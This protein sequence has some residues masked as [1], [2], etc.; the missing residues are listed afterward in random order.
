MF[1]LPSFFVP[2]LSSHFSSF[3]L[4]LLSSASSTQRIINATYYV[5]MNVKPPTVIVIVCQFQSRE[6]Y[7]RLVRLRD[8]GEC[9]LEKVMLI[10]TIV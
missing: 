5:F 1:T 6:E 7:V 4:F 8:S 2:L 3:L 10:L 9:F